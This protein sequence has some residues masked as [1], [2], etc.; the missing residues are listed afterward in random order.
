MKTSEKQKIAVYYPA[1]LGGGAEAVGLW[2]MEA[3]KQKYD[4]TLFTISAVDFEK[5]NLMYGT[6]LSS[7]VVQVKSFFSQYFSPLANSL[8]ANSKP[9]RMFFFHLLLRY[10]KSKSHHYDLLISAY[11]AVDFGKQG[12]QYIHWIK[13]LEGNPFYERISD[14]SVERLK[15]NISITN[16]YTVAEYV[17]KA[18]GSDS[19]LLYPPVVLDVKEIPWNDKEDAFI[20]SGRLTEAKQPHKVIQILKQVRERGFDIK[21]YMTGGGGGAYAWK[22][23]NFLKKLA[24]ENAAWV[25][26]Y[27]NLT[28]EDYVKVVLK[29][30]Y[31]IHFKQEPFG[32][33]IAEMVKA[34]VIPFVR[35]QGGQVEIVGVH[36]QDLFFDNEKDAIEKIVNVL[37]HS[38]RQAKLMNSL[39]EQRHLFSTQRFMT[40][41]NKIVENYFAKSVEL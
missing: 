5:L 10:L 9:I 20:C 27:E 40:E 28:Y 19:T 25:R 21:L 33:S 23:Q 2:M 38:D 3:L 26:L 17:S 35:S 36:N 12:M 1:F 16:S 37:S 22:Y 41:M 31:G 24:R 8:V 13:V 15:D 30:K 34:G 4:L 11:N 39:A 7:N 29:C 32:I 6:S 14:F 18:Y